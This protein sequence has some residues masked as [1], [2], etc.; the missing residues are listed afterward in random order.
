MK[1]K[2]VTIDDQLY[3]MD[4]E[5]QSFLKVS[6][7]LGK[8][9]KSNITLF[10]CIIK[11]EAK[12]ETN[13]KINYKCGA[14]NQYGEEVIPCI[15]DSLKFNHP[16][17]FMYEYLIA[18]LPPCN[19]FSMDYDGIPFYVYENSY[20]KE[21]KIA[22]F[23]GYQAIGTFKK[24]LAIA[25][26]DGYLGVVRSDGRTYIKPEFDNVNL[27][28]ENEHI[29]LKKGEQSVSF[30]YHEN[31]KNWRPLPKYHS[32]L[33]YDKQEKHFLVKQEDKIGV[34]DFSNLM[35]IP[36][37]Y[38]D[39]VFCKDIIIATNSQG[40]KGIIKRSFIINDCQTILLDFDYT[41]FKFDTHKEFIIATNSQCKK[42]IINCSDC[43]TILLDFEYDEIIQSYQNHSPDTYTNN[44]IIIKND[45]QGVCTKKGKILIKPI[46]K[47]DIC[48]YPNTFD[49]DLI[50]FRKEYKDYNEYTNEWNTVWKD[51]FINLN[52]EIALLFDN[53]SIKYGFNTKDGRAIIINWITDILYYERFINKQ[54][55]I[56]EEKKT[57]IFRRRNYY[58][59]DNE[60]RK[61]D[62]WDALTDGHYGDYPED[63]WDIDD[64]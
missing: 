9:E 57:E 19:F 4:F 5:N 32:F 29:I 35:L 30:L 3:L 20:G 42:G 49:G 40:K 7:I 54:G 12:I 44:L 58:N 46:F 6:A 41:D 34:L 47:K 48:I 13:N 21:K 52:G 22:R 56:L 51:G 14:V 16:F 33:K 11:Q 61:R 8:D 27:D 23:F 55:E 50:G 64:Y 36:P 24:G 63:G 39:L 15:Y 43:Q 60:E 45:L 18:S 25:I 2:I 38:T 31:L 62:T 17:N 59:D 37:I 53:Y 1:R 10:S 26:K 28:I